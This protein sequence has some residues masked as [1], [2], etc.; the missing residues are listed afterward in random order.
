MIADRSHCRILA[1]TIAI[2]L[3]LT[4]TIAP[5]RSQSETEDTPDEKV[6]LEQCK[7]ARVERNDGKSCTERFALGQM[8][9]KYSMWDEAGGQFL[10]ILEAFP[11]DTA[12]RGNLAVCL[13]QNG[14]TDPA[15]EQYKYILSKE[16]KNQS[17]LFN[18]AAAY[19]V[20]KDWDLASQYCKSILQLNP[21][22][23]CAYLG[24]SQCFREKHDERAAS[25]L[26]KR[27]LELRPEMRQNKLELFPPAK[28][29]IPHDDHS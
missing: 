7:L 25:V 27:G 18:L 14:Y 8:L 11:N 22:N 4:I 17:A 26:L 2:T 24:L 3:G 21:A 20:K 15:I 13:Q 28:D 9:M 6:L 12:A 19:S 23:A 5:L 10:Q 1:S 16:P 29:S